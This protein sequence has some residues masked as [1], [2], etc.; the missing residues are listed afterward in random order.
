[1]NPAHELLREDSVEPFQLPSTLG[2][3][4]SPVDQTDVVVAAELAE[5]LRDEATAVVH[6]DRRGLPPALERPPEVVGGLV[7]P[8]PPMAAGHP[9]E[10]GP[11]IQN[12]VNVDLPL[13]S[14]DAEP[15]HV[16]LPE[17]V[18]EVSLEPLERLGLRDDPNHE[19]VPLQN[20]VNGPPARPDTPTGEDGVDPL[21]SPRRMSLPQLEDV[22]DEVPVD[23]V[24]APVGAARVVPEPIH[25]LFSVVSAPTSKGALGDPE[26]LADFGGAN[27]PIQVLLDDS[28]TEANIFCDQGD[29]FPGPVICPVS[30]AGQMSWQCTD[31]PPEESGIRYVPIPNRIALQGALPDPL[32]STARNAPCIPAS[33]SEPG[34]SKKLCGHDGFR[35]G[36]ITQWTIRPAA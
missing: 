36:D 1:V 16:H 13:H 10:A 12:G 35:P 31:R 18:H 9:Q 28:Q 32:T 21:R 27:P 11:V 20:A 2:I 4:R 6:G 25:A 33:S 24:R 3:V 5:L 19:P 8:L 14:L 17:G 7:G 22:I 34:A 29:P 15:V 26:E 23:P 30:S